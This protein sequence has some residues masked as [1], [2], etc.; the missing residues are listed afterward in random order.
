MIRVLSPMRARQMLLLHA[1]FAQCAWLPE[2]VPVYS[3]L[4]ECGGVCVARGLLNP[5][6]R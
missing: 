5:E 4:Y 2:G 3:A 1:T 6:G